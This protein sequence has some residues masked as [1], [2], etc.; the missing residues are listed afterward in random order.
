MPDIYC[1]RSHILLSVSYFSSQAHAMASSLVN[2]AH[3]AANIFLHLYAN[4]YQSSNLASLA[5]GSANLFLGTQ[6]GDVQILSPA[7]KVVRS[8]HAHDS[9]S[10][11]HMK[12]INDTSLLVTIAEDLSSDPVLKVWAL[13]KLDKKSGE[14]RCLSSLEIQNGRRMFPVGRQDQVQKRADAGQISAFA[15]LD[16]LSQLA[17]GFANGSVTMVRGDLI[18]DRGAKQRTIFESQ[19]PITGVEFRKG[20]SL[21]TLYLATTGRILTLTISG[22]G[23]GLPARPLEDTGCGVGCMTFNE[24][25]REI[26][27]VRDDAI[28][29]YGAHGRGPPSAYE[30]PKQLVKIFGGFVVLVS[31]PQTPTSKSSPLRYFGGS[32]ADEVFSTS[33]FS[34]LDTD[35]R[36]IAHTESLTSPVK[37]VFIEWGDLFLLTLDGKVCAIRI[38]CSADIKRIAVPLS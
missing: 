25:T 35:L 20:S 17:I 18:H 11:T 29:Y 36:Y 32:R 33:T 34:L 37:Q 10:I 19:E 27:V 28:S 15:T 22:K 3:E 4:F 2:I 13:D 7:F 24:N 23:Q 8:F 30:G 21:T 12:Q 5:S 31:P 38:A 1:F 14:P 6:S 26:I 9:G 16:D